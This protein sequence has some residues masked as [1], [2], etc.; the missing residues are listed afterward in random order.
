MLFDEIGRVF[1]DDPV[2]DV[3]VKLLKTEG[4]RSCV[5]HYP[6]IARRNIQN[7]AT[8][9]YLERVNGQVDG[10]DG[11]VPRGELHVVGKVEVLWGENRME[12]LGII[13][14]ERCNPHVPL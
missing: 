7:V 14:P 12:Y 5:S 2:G 1:D 11:Y 8:P 9:L 3:A 4:G 10:L 13:E 6:G